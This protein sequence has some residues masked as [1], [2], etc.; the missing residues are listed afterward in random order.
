[1]IKKKL[2]GKTTYQ[3]KT[4]FRAWSEEQ[5]WFFLHS[6]LSFDLEARLKRSLY[7]P[8]GILGQLYQSQKWEWKK[9]EDTT[10]KKIREP[11]EI[12][13]QGVYCYLNMPMLSHWAWKWSCVFS[14]YICT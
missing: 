14:S 10:I 13:A 12:F 3:T 11:E 5:F 8:L 2:M 1:M 9:A 7:F 6:A 4:D